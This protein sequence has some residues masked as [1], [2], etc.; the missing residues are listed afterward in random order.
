VIG[1]SR[2]SA[3]DLLEGSTPSPIRDAGPELLGL[4]GLSFGLFLLPLGLLRSLFAD[5]RD[6]HTPSVE[7]PS[8]T[9]TTA[10]SYSACSVSIT[11]SS[12]VDGE[13][14]GKELGD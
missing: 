13:E 3:R 6:M 8:A 1:H 2:F 5:N 14:E 10:S 12:R 4:C 9:A 11:S 7:A